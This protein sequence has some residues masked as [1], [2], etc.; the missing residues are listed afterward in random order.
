MVAYQTRFGG[1]AHKE[2][3]VGKGGSEINTIIPIL[4]NGKVVFVKKTD[5]TFEEKGFKISRAPIIKEHRIVDVDENYLDR[6]LKNTYFTFDFS[7]VNSGEGLEVYT[8]SLGGSETTNFKKFNIGLENRI[9]DSRSAFGI[10][11]S[12][13]QATN[14]VADIKTAI[15]GGEY[16]YRV[17]KL[18]NAASLE[19]YAGLFLSA[20]ITVDAVRIVQTNSGFPTRVAEEL[21]GSLW[22]HKYGARLRVF[23]YASY[24]LYGHFGFSKYKT[25]GMDIGTSSSG[26]DSKLEE[27]GGLD[28][29]LGI[30]VNL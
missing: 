15:V 21:Y 14:E 24:S 26:G 18:F 10:Y 2:I 13:L 16:Q 19:L 28:I 7:A 17:L 5:V 22:G 25:I 11:F 3:T 4:L 8:K 30:S 9:I 20:D 12:Y 27:F 23:P 29:G 6:L 1:P